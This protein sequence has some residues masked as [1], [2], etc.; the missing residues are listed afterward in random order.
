[1][2][3]LDRIGG[4]DRLVLAHMGGNQ[5][6]SEVYDTLAGE[7]VYFDTAYVLQFF[8]ASQFEKMLAKHGEDKILFASD[9]PWSDIGRDVQILK[10]FSLNQKTEQKILC[11]NAKKLLEL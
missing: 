6:F 11:E 8:S 7:D 2:R 9:S 5:L 3:V 1:M 10:S 4:Y